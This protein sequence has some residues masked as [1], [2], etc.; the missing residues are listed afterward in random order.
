MNYKCVDCY[1]GGS[2][3]RWTQVY[4]G[5][6]GGGFNA[7]PAE[8]E[9]S[10]PYCGGDVTT[11]CA[12]CEGCGSVEHLVDLDKDGLCRLCVIDNLVEGK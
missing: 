11:E 7:E 2:D 5:T 4:E 12:A 6:P 8:Y 1:W 9:A 3:P 10:C